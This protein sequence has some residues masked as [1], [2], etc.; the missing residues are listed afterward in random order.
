MEKY[1]PNSYEIE[2]L[3]ML[4]GERTWEWGSW[5]GACLEFLGEAGLCS[6]VPPYTITKK[7]EKAL[8]EGTR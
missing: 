3:K 8:E 2:V 4:N 6:R 1:I 5:V 7:G